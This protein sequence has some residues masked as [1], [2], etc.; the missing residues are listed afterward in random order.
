[1]SWLQFL[2]TLNLEPKKRKSVTA[3]AFSPSVCH[4]VMGSDAMVL[5]F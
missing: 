3:S 4:E 1:M 2:C 5:D